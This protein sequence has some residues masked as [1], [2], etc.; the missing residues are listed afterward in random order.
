MQD[1]KRTLIAIAVLTLVIFGIYKLI[2]S[3]K[4]TTQYQTSMVEKGTI[5]SSVSAS[6]Q[7]I[8]SNTLNISTQAVGVVKSVL[9]KDGDKVSVGQTIATITLDP[10]GQQQ[11]DQAYSSY[12]S[13]K[14]SLTNANISFYT[15][16]A[17]EFAANYK[18]I[19]DAVA[20]NLSTSDPTY[21]QENAT[22]L[23]AEAQYN[24]QQNVI[25]VAK[26]SLGNAWLNYTNVSP[27]ITAP[28]PGTID[29][30]TLTPGMV[31]S[32]GSS[33]S[34]TTASSQ[35][36]AVIRTEGNPIA[37]FNV[38]EIDVSKI[39]Y[40]QKA[41]ITLDSLTDITFTGKVVSVDRIGSVTS[42]VTNYPVIIAFDTGNN[43]VLPNMSATAN[44]ITATKDSVL[45]IPTTAI[46]TQSGQSVVRI[47][48]KNNQITT[49]NVTTGLSSD[50]QTEIIS[51]VSEGQNVITSTVFSG[52]T[53][54]SGSSIFSSLGGGA[55]TSGA[56]R[57]NTSGR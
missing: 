6:G 2:S 51:G 26:V 42:G 32:S 13:A 49:V 28:T 4:T 18:F 29:N 43:Q 1:K 37:T 21:I 14:N 35:R 33:S 8:S 20:R 9:V 45:L 11:A 41:T 12:L 30:I 15:L 57:V 24:N 55:R 40:G 52:T 38:S 27:T 48:D 23:A 36:I 31:I 5:I 34:T 3:K 17:S 44:I 19:N 25:A 46:Q 53:T 22:W 10:T 39:K 7:I 16:Q 50:T 56:V 47:M 54:T